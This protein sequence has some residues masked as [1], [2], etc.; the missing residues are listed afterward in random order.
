MISVGSVLSKFAEMS[1]ELSIDSDRVG[2]PIVWRTVLSLSGAGLVIA[3]FDRAIDTSRGFVEVRLFGVLDRSLQR[4]LS[5]LR[6]Q[7]LYRHHRVTIPSHIPTV[8]MVCKGPVAAYDLTNLNL[9]LSVKL[10]EQKITS[11]TSLTNW[12]KTY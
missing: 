7:R 6:V 3:W 2:G 12:S 10:T 5:G 4:G 11:K 8:H 9:K 1:R